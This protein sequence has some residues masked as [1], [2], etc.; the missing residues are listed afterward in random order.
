MIQNIIKVYQCWFMLIFFWFLPLAFY[1]PSFSIILLTARFY[2]KLYFYNIFQG[3]MI[4]LFTSTI[5]YYLTDILLIIFMLNRQWGSLHPGEGHRRSPR[6]GAQ[7]QHACI[8]HREGSPLLQ[9][10]QVDTSFMVT[11]FHLYEVTG[12]KIV[13]PVF[14]R[15]HLF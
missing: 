15:S 8:F 3:R 2:G 6:A 11:A 7:E 1:S 14:S 12:L 10:Y 13:N 9:I 4:V 5:A